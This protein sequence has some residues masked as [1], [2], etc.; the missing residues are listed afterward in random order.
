V[1]AKIRSY[2]ISH[3]H[4][5]RMREL[6]DDDSLLEARVI[7]SLGVLE[8]VAYVEETFAIEVTDDDLTPENFESIGALARFVGKRSERQ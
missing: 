1:R 3:F 2:V 7:D 5:S 4:L 8:L 6:G